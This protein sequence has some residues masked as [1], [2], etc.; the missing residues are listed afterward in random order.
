MEFTILPNVPG[1]AKAEIPTNINMKRK[2]I[3]VTNHI[4][5]NIIIS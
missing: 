4:N 1:R 5:P 3:I 2:I